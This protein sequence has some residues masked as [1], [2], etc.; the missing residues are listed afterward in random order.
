MIEGGATCGAENGGGF[1]K[2]EMGLQREQ[3]RTAFSREDHRQLLVMA[4]N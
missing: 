1:R 3:G 2:S 4:E